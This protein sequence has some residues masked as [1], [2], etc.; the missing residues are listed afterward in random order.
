MSLL[1]P[2][3]LEGAGAVAQSLAY[4]TGLAGVVVG[5]VVFR[6]GQTFLALVVWILTFALG[7]MLMIAAFLVRGMAALLGRVARIESDLG[8]LL[9]DRASSGTDDW[10][11]RPPY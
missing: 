1:S 2:K 3:D 9:G 10:G 4:V 6:D 11:D 5:A 8:V 7:A